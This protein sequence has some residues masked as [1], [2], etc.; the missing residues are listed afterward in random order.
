MLM[1]SLGEIILPL[2][3]VQE[4]HRIVEVVRRFMSLCDDLESRLLE[5]DSAQSA[6]AAAAS[7]HLAV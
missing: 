2:P 3:P 5:K 4:Q 7:H 1:A 6:F